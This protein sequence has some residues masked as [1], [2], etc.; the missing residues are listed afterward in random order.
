[1]M[2]KWLALMTLVT[3][4]VPALAQPSQPRVRPLPPPPPERSAPGLHTHDHNHVH[5]VILANRTFYIASC[6]QKDLYVRCATLPA[7]R[8][9]ALR[10]QRQTGH[11]TGVDKE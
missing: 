7:A 5:T 9:V 2:K 8:A 11:R 6:S 10:H 3:L 4:S 1:M